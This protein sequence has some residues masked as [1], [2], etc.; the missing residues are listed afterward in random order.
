MRMGRVLPALAVLTAALASC[1]RGH[2]FNMDLYDKVLPED[3][4]INAAVMAGFAYHAAMR[5]DMIPR[6]LR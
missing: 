5:E 4:K 1:A 2:H 6:K 3:L